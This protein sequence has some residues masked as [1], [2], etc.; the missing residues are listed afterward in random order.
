MAPPTPPSSVLPYLQSAAAGT[1]LPLTVVEAQNYAESGYGSNQGPSSAGAIGPWQFEPST[2]TGLGFPAGTEWDWAES[3]KAYEKYM[4]ELLSQEGGSIFR[5]LEAY[6]AGP[7]NLGAGAGYASGI[8]SSA[9][10]SSGATAS[11]GSGPGSVGTLPPG[12][13][14]GAAG[15]AQGSTSVGSF[16]NGILAG[17]GFGGNV[18]IPSWSDLFQR[19]GLILLGAALLIIG[20]H[21]MVGTTVNTIISPQQSPSPSEP[22]VQPATSPVGKPA[23][24][25]AGATKATTSTAATTGKAATASESLGVGSALDAAVVA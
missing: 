18:G 7:G 5:A 15:P 13:S 1:N 6:N 24:R 9:G 12:A 23:E 22:P 21:M 10:V 3:T 19:L 8:L 25:E 16:L 20:I 11:G 4:N 14:T 17:L 2:Y